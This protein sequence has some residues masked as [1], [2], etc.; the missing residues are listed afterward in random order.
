MLDGLN[1]GSWQLVAKSDEANDWFS[2]AYTSGRA[3]DFAFETSLLSPFAISFK[4]GNYF[5]LFYFG[6]ASAVE[7]LAW[8][9]RPVI[10]D[11]GPYGELSH[12]SL[13]A[14]ERS[15]VVIPE[16]STGILMIVGL[17]GLGMVAR[18][19]RVGSA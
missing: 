8:D 18:R 19:R 17:A 4:H 3:G 6:D 2:A 13:W 16:P 15:A 9:L 12:A 5:Q 14:V 1:A 7:G 11:R 10:G